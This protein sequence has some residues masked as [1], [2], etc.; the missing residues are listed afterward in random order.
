MEIIAKIE[1]SKSEEYK[2]NELDEY[3]H[4]IAMYVNFISH[5]SD[6]HKIDLIFSR[7]ASISDTFDEYKAQLKK[8]V[9]IYLML[10]SFYFD[11]FKYLQKNTSSY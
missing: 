7:E 6:S 11:L 5:K 10:N 9:L 3:L 8:Y 4:I 1:N 2:E